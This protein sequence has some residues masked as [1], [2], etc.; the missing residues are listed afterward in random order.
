M[1]SQTG[2]QTARD[3]TYQFSAV[4]LWLSGLS[5]PMGIYNDKTPGIHVSWKHKI[6]ILSF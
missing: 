2:S 4:A 3:L 5:G 1:E 6:F